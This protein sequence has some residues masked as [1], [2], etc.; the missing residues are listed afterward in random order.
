QTCALPI[1]HTEKHLIPNVKYGGGSLMLW[2]CF[3]SKGPGHLI[4][5]QGVMEAIKYQQILN[6]ILTA[7]SMKLGMGRGWTFQQDND[8]KA[9]L[10]INTRMVHR[11]QNKGF[12]MAITLPRLKPHRKSEIGS[13]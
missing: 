3:S 6:E 10:K 13:A 1:C 12:A 5:I 11:P 2:G 8:P 9:H 4:R 7:P